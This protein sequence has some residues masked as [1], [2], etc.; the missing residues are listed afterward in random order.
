MWPNPDDF[1]FWSSFYF[2]GKRRLVTPMLRIIQR[3]GEPKMKWW[4]WSFFHGKAVLKF[5]LRI[6]I[7]LPNLSVQLSIT[8]HRMFSGTVWSSMISRWP[9]SFRKK[10]W[11]LRLSCRSAT[12]TCE[13][14]GVEGI[15]SGLAF[16]VEWA[17]R[18]GRLLF[19][20][21]DSFHC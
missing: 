7:R 18:Q 9:S 8:W 5:I 16:S 4:M 6:V 3:Y 1:T 13:D 10:I 17:S 11:K 19:C 14:F 21:S 12:K 2:N 20:P 15:V